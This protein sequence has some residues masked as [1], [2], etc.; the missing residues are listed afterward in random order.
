MSA[1]PVGNSYTQSIV[2]DGVK[3]KDN[4]SSHSAHS[5]KSQHDVAMNADA[6]ESMLAL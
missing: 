3:I 5:I 4:K 1:F 2:S 6:P